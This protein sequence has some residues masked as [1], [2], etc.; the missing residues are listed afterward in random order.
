MKIDLLSNSS[1]MLGK[2]VYGL[3][4]KDIGDMRQRKQDKIKISNC[5]GDV[6]EPAR[7]SIYLL[8]K[9]I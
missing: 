1:I 5:S 4:L 3:R 2:A 6:A 9:I 7:A 8:K